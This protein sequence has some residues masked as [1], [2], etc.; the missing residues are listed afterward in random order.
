M[1]PYI[2]VY[3]DFFFINLFLINKE[4]TY[5]PPDVSLQL[6]GVVAQYTCIVNSQR[7]DI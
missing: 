7:F 6:F 1:P 2:L 5:I 3:L 4:H